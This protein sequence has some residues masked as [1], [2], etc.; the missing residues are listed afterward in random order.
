MKLLYILWIFA[1]AHAAIVGIDYGHQFTKAIMVAPGIPFEIVFTDEGKRKDLSAISIKPLLKSKNVIDTERVYGSQIGSL[2]TRFPESCASNLKRLLGKSVDD[3]LV[4]E[5]L[6]THFGVTLAKG[7][8]RD[9]ISLRLGSGKNVAEFPV[10]EIAA[11]SLNHLKERVL[12]TL[13]SNPDAQSKAEDVAVA[14][15]AYASQLV[16]FSYLDTLELAEYSSVL[17]LVD[18]GT[19][20]AVAFALNHKLTDE[21]YDDK[22]LYYVVYDVGAGST[23][24]TLFS[25]TPFANRTVELNIESVGY[26]ESFGGELF[27]TEV[28]KLMIEKAREKFNLDPSD[29]L[30]PRLASR[31]RE[32]AEKAKII[33]SANT[34]YRTTLESFY[35]DKDFKFTLTREEY[36]NALSG[37][38]E[39]S[40]QPILDALTTASGEKREISDIQA[41]ILN[42]G[43]SR[44]PFI[45]KQLVSLLGSEEKIAKV[46]NTDEACA[47]GT[48]IQAYNWKTLSRSSPIIVNDRI[49]RSFEA[50]VG[51]RE[52]LITIFENGSSS[53]NETVVSLG[54]LVDDLDI[55]LFEDG[56]PFASF[57]I[58]GLLQK[59]KSMK[60]KPEK[61]EVFGTFTVDRSKLFTMSKAVI[62]C[63]LEDEESSVVEES[64]T[65]S[66]STTTKKAT[67]V[68]VSLPPKK[69]T[70]LRPLTRFEKQRISKQLT[71]LKLR[72]L[73]KVKFEE[74]K[75]I[76]ES[77]CYSLRNIIE[78]NRDILSN[79]MK[80]E[81]LEELSELASEVV[82]WLEYDAD[83]SG[84]EAIHEKA[85][86]IAGHKDSVE[87]VIRMQFADL[88]QARLQELYKQSSNIASQ[89]QNF[90]LE[91][92]QQ[93][94]LLREKYEADSI[95]FTKENEKAMKLIYGKD[96]VS[97]LKID[98]LF[99]SLK[100]S[101]KELSAVV[102]LSEK[103]FNNIDRN[104]LFEMTEKIQ[105]LV[106]E[107]LDEITSLQAS[108]ERRMN[109]LL[110]Q[111]EKIKARNAQKE[112]KKKLKE[113][114]EL[115]KEQALAEDSGEAYIEQED[116]DIKPED[117]ESE[118]IESSLDGSEET[119]A[120]ESDKSD[121]SLNHDEL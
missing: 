83:E 113:E 85:K 99:S 49:F 98:E 19:A 24:A 72:D 41:V 18:E 40:T 116:M 56:L 8:S 79:E 28:Y 62:K 36:E 54:P 11:M 26:D 58:S 115:E 30:S 25:Y 100:L 77:A 52:E 6:Q 112:F 22:T 82:E 27:T 55:T 108:H 67:S 32:T 33:L 7:D 59:S 106:E 97:G 80:H 47:L 14:V 50:S 87:R 110:S 81:M 9:N 121:D 96:K 13:D 93:V 12:K 66:N 68:N 119:G 2:C 94:S 95:D 109:F 101:L 4:S 31:L 84:I 111:Y 57:N 61:R 3:D 38:L 71:E 15:G 1:V 73:E 51:G 88:S 91:F 107:M 23:S 89:V 44:T 34:E 86:M 20:V 63:A 75:N 102:D 35:D 29:T 5:Y 46:V 42:G 120:I 92:G 17:G 48:A 103:E 16:R 53:S 90:F 37:L 78:D 114:Q 64:S 76:L 74:T 65:A 69:F 70:N 117:T 118:T 105:T 43:S 10:E 60:C 39:R 45:Q 104:T 21:Q